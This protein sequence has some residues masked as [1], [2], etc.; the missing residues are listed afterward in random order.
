M[1]YYLWIIEI[2]TENIARGFAEPDFFDIYVETL[3]QAYFQ[4]PQL[5]PSAS[6]ATSLHEL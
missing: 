4:R 1:T 6:R 3:H 2:E 5:P